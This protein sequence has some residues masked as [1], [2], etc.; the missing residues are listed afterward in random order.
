VNV[1]LESAWDAPFP[2]SQVILILLHSECERLEKR[3]IFQLPD[4]PLAQFNPV[5]QHQ[6]SFEMSTAY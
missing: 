2:S 1:L 4:A 6:L 5:W 3:L